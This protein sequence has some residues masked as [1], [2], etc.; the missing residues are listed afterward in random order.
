MKT[1]ITEIGN[2]SDAIFPD[3][4]NRIPVHSLAVVMIVGAWEIVDWKKVIN[5]FSSVHSVGFFI[6]SIV[7]TLYFGYVYGILI[8]A[9]LYIIYSIIF[10]KSKTHESQIA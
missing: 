4:I 6:I 1:A 2:F 7:S 5:A 9:V 3:V 10:R 8:S